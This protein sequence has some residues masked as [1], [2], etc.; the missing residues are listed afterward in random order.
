VRDYLYD[1]AT[2]GYLPLPIRL[3]LGRGSL[4]FTTGFLPPRFREAMRLTWTDRDQR[5]LSTSFA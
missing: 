3:L 2:L 1:L 4:F 5:A